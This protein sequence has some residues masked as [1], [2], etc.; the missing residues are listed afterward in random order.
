MIS[1]QIKTIAKDSLVTVVITT[2]AITVSILVFIVLKIAWKFSSLIEEIAFKVKHEPLKLELE[3]VHL[4]NDVVG[5]RTTT[6]SGSH[7]ETNLVGLKW[8]DGYA[9]AGGVLKCEGDV[10]FR[11]LI[12]LEGKLSV[13][14]LVRWDKFAFPHDPMRA[15][16]IDYKNTYFMSPIG[17]FAAWQFTG[18]KSTWVIFIHGHRSNRAECLRL[19]PL[20]HDMGFPA[21]S[22]T[23]RNDKDSPLDPSGYHQFG[24]TEWEDLQGAVEFALDRGASKVILIGHSFGGS[25]IGSFIYRSRLNSYVVGTVLDSPLLDLGM[26]AVHEGKK[27][28]LPALMISFAKWIAS[29]RFGI[30]WESLD[31]LTNASNFTQPILLI[32]GDKD[33]VVP[34][35]MSEQLALMRP[36]IVTLIKLKGSTHVAG[37]NS[38]RNKYESEIRSFLKR[39]GA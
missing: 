30:D 32:H 4:D 8:A 5:L 17:R 15:H 27:R 18:Q 19:L 21:L 2:I 33:P 26:V 6:G 34:F 37:W 12:S 9:Q 22:I 3:V 20:V 39:V 7:M 31:Y 38:H 1:C 14:D 25:V 13:G 10:V 16:E 28:H 11:K 24:L 23:Y 29:R 35:S 36:D